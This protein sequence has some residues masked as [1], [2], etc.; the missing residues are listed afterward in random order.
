MTYMIKEL[1][2]STGMT[3][4]EFAEH[5]GIPMSTLRKWEQ[6]ESS[7][8]PYV[9]Y[10]LA[11]TLPSIRA[12]IREITVGEKKYYYDKNKKKIYDSVGNGIKVSEDIDGIKE[13]NLEIYIE[14]LFE[15]FY[16]AQERFDRDCRL[17][18]EEDIIWSR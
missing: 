4:R 7:P 17:D 3:Q 13:K 12:S 1:R 15:A 2:N 11:A 8:A 5:Y 6:G 18:R 16:K 9:I 14:D 10:L